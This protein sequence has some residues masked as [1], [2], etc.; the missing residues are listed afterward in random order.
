VVGVPYCTAVVK[1]REGGGGIDLTMETLGG[2]TELPVKS[3][4]LTLRRPACIVDVL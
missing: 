4:K 1:F 2:M 3:T